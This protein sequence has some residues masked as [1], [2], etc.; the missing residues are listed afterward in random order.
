MKIAFMGSPDF[1]VPSLEALVENRFEVCL[2]VTQ[3]DRRAGR[4]RKML[5]TAV[6]AAAQSHGLPVMDFGKGDGKAVT[7]A[8]LAENPDAVVVVAFGHI[9]REPLLSTPPTKKF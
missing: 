7:A 8:I 4:G 3:P 2:V 6:K 1:A 9:L 5:P